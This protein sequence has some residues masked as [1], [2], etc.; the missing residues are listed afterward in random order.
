MKCGIVIPYRDRL[1]N[2]KISLPIIKSRLDKL[3]IEYEIAIV[4]QD[5]NKPFI[6]GL[7]IILIYN[8]N[9]IF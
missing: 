9:F 5:D 3:D 7:I 2:L 8:S 6:R 4:N 1:N